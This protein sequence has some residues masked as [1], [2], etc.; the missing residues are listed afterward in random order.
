MIEPVSDSV[1]AGVGV[2]GSLLKGGEEEI[3]TLHVLEYSIL[4][5]LSLR[6]IYVFPTESLRS[7]LCPDFP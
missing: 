6:E 7:D 3:F 1:R 5:H 4:R 2:P